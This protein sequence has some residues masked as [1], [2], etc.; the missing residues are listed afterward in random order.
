MAFASFLFRYAPLI[1]LTLLSHSSSLVGADSNC[2]CVSPVPTPSV[3]PAAP[4]G[5]DA[6]G[7]HA[8]DAHAK[9][10]QYNFQQFVRPDI[11]APRWD[12]TIYNESALSPGYWFVAPYQEVV[13]KRR[14]GNWVGPHIYDQTGELIWSGAP[15]FNGFDVF[16]TRCPLPLLRA[17]LLIEAMQASPREMT[18]C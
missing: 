11:D 3:A 10:H 9:S 5:Y 17:C 15:L 8:I 7:S 16:G 6:P 18:K 4:N 12:L 2:T 1:G 14:G 13:Q